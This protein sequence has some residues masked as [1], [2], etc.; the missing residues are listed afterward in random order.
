MFNFYGFE[1]HEHSPTGTGSLCDVLIR[2]TG[3]VKD[4]NKQAF[5]AEVMVHA[6]QNKIDEKWSVSFTNNGDQK[7]LQTW[8]SGILAKD[9][10]GESVFESTELTRGAE[11]IAIGFLSATDIFLPKNISLNGQLCNVLEDS[12]IKDAITLR[13]GEA[14]VPDTLCSTYLKEAESPEEQALKMY[15][16]ESQDVNS[17]SM[18]AVSVPVA[19]LS[20]MF[21]FLL[22]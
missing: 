20:V 8:G 22:L 4:Q 3:E 13:S 21:G 9:F 11:E 17:A 14:F 2:I 18:S 10:R 1:E 12:G 16:Y 6:K 15:C 7:L 19:L 5:T